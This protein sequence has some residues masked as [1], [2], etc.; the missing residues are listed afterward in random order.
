MNL[1]EEDELEAT[2]KVGVPIPCTTEAWGCMTP[3]PPDREILGKTILNYYL[4]AR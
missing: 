2:V 4:C 3:T 1:L